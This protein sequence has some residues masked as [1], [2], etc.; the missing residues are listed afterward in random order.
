[1]M[2]VGREAQEGRLGDEGVVRSSDQ[3]LLVKFQNFTEEWMEVQVGDFPN[4]NGRTGFQFQNPEFYFFMVS[5]SC[6]KLQEP[7]KYVVCPQCF[8]T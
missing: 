2:K 3:I 1:M 4:T 6:S 8:L 5:F 7:L